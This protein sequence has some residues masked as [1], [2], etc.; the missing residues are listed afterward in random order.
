MKSAIQDPAVRNGAALKR[1]VALT[2]AVS[3]LLTR[4]FAVGDDNQAL[5]RASSMWS[6]NREKS[7]RLQRFGHWIAYE[8]QYVGVVWW[9]N[10]STGLGSW[11]TPPEVKDF[12]LKT[13][14]P[15]TKVQ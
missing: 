14:S 9:Y 6:L 3:I 7:V 12:N 5:G 10:T 8:D 4:W 1:K 13:H 11:A 2:C 15:T